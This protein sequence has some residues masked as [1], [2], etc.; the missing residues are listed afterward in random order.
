LNLGRSVIPIASKSGVARR[1]SPA[2]AYASCLVPG[3]GDYGSNSEWPNVRPESLTRL[4]IGKIAKTRQS[5]F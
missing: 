2:V 3:F 5:A 4:P 1:L